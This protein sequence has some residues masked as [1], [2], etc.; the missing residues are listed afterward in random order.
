MLCS[1]DPPV[2]QLELALRVAAFGGS[3]ASVLD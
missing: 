1:F 3:A 2:S